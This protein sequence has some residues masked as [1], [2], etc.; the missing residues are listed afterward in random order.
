[1]DGP[2]ELESDGGRVPMEGGREGTYGGRKRGYLWREGGRVPME[3]GYLWRA[4]SVH[5]TF[6][7]T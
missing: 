7:P 2:I 4:I 3:G 5:P 1:M 6:T